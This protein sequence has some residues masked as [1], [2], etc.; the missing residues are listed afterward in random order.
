LSRAAPA[1]TV[2]R[3]TTIG[4]RDGPP[5]AAL[6]M[7]ARFAVVPDDRDSPLAAFRL[8]VRDFTRGIEQATSPAPNFTDGWRCQQVLDAIPTSS[9]EGRTV[10][11]D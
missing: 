9:R 4:G 10:T 2:R 1:I 8:P 11:S 6:P 5:L 7:P 3:R